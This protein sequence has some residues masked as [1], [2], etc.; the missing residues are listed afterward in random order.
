MSYRTQVIFHVGCCVSQAL[1]GRWSRLP[2]HFKGIAR[3]I[4]RSSCPRGA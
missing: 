3:A 2:F 1:R 4:M